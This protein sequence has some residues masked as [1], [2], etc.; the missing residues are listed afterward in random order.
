MIVYKATNIINNKVYIGITTK[1][2]E[3]RV[4][5]HKKDSKVKNTYLYRAIR[6]YGFENFIWEEIDTANSI[7]E[8]HEKEIFYIKKYDSFDNKEKGYN[9]TSGGYNLY[10]ITDEERK[11][12]SERARGENNPMYGTPSPLKGKKFTD[13]HK[14]KISESLKKADRPHVKRANNP[15]SRKVINL[16]TGEIFD[17]LTDAAEKYNISRQM[18]GKVCNGH[19]KTAKGYHW[20]FLEDYKQV[21]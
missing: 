15:A 10:D 8:L 7:E 12:R 21:M 5:I 14:K 17:T 1:T 20:M 9:T 18:I 16:D 3:H 19:N 2:L 13:E 11:K 4:S 6:K